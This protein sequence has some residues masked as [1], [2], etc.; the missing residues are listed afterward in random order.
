M[1]GESQ[2]HHKSITCKEKSDVVIIKTYTNLPASLH[3][4]WISQ[5]R[6]PL[7][8]LIKCISVYSLASEWKSQKN[9]K[10]LILKPQNCHNLKL[11][12][13]PFKVLYNDIHCTETQKQ[14][15]ASNNLWQYVWDTLP[16]TVEKWN[17]HYYSPP[18]ITGLLFFCDVKCSMFKM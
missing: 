10:N 8:V 2:H 5:M 1:C 15:H 18:S 7:Y 9:K 13:D 3:L 16:S 12:S 14:M 4:D 11:K 17:I 6:W